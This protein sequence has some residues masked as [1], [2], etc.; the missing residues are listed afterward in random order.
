MAIAMAMVIVMAIVM[1]VAMTI[2]VV[3]SAL[4]RKQATDLPL[5]KLTKIGQNFQILWDIRPQHWKEEVL[6]WWWYMNIWMW[7]AMVAKVMAISKDSY[8]LSL[9]V[10]GMPLYH[11]A[12]L[13][14][15]FYF[16]RILRKWKWDLISSYK[17]V[18]VAICSPHILISSKL[19]SSA[20]P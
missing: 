1:T 9:P 14:H 5:W 8:L 16:H 17:K 11:R 12:Q 6:S 7:K 2:V 4:F 3:I 15:S 20:L 19:L 10:L 13:S 18:K